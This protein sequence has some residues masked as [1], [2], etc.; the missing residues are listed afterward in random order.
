MYNICKWNRTMFKVHEGRFYLF[1]GLA[2]DHVV[3]ISI[4]VYA[5]AVINRIDSANHMDQQRTML[6]A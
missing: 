4:L 6:S 3:S 5:T 1:N 2:E